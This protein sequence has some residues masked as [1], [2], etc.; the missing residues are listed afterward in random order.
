MKVAF[1]SSKPYDEEYF[2]K[3]NNKNGLTFTFFETS[4][5]ASTVNLTKDFDAI[6]GFVND[7]ITEYVVKKM[8]ANGVRLIALRCAGFNN[9]DI[10]AANDYNIPVVRVPAYSPESIAE[11][12]LALILTLNRKTHKAYNRVREGNFSLNRLIGF[13]LHDKTVAVIGTGKIGVAICHILKGFGC[14]IV[15]FDP[16]PQD[17]LIA[18][19]V[20]YRSLENCL[21]NADVV[22]LHCPLTPDTKHMINKGS[23]AQM[24]KGVMIINTS[25]GG[26]INTADVI[27]GLTN[28]KI[29]YL[30]I[31]VYEQ[32][33]N[34]FYK[35]LSENIIQDEQILRLNS[36]PNVLIT[37]HQAY[38][39]Y[40]AMTQITQVTVQNIL[41][42]KNK[43]ELKN[44]VTV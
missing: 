24:K 17:H 18:L 6:C 3:A 34:L 11:H 29:G 20:E 1:F 30:G 10:Q 44:K 14:N 8:H 13:N 23:I 26:L 12:A 40:E 7:K 21:I 25:R 2:E 19:G 38:F 16:Y 15:A 27:N 9:V 32:E 43:H 4:L 28:K 37:A 5:N 39:T 33:E 36:F 31:D 22:T 42:F 35:D 41:A